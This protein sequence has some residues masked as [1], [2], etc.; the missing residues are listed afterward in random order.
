MAWCLNYPVLKGNA[1]QSTKWRLDVRKRKTT[2]NFNSVAEK[3]RKSEP[4]WQTL[5]VYSNNFLFASCNFHF[6]PIRQLSL[7]LSLACA[8]SHSHPQTHTT[9][10][11]THSTDSNVAQFKTIGDNLFTGIVSAHTKFCFYNWIRIRSE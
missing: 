7:S 9:R 2:K 3:E 1:C 11:H 4:Q 10:T 6:T 8:S 5:S